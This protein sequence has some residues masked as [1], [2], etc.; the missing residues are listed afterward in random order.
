MRI[1]GA[2]AGF[3]LLLTILW[4]AFETIIL[5]RRVVRYYFRLTRAFYRYT[6]TP[7]AAIA[8][9]LK[10]GRWRESFLSYF[11]PLSLLFLF[12][13][14]A[15]G[16]IFS[17]ALLQWSAGS[18]VRLKGVHPSFWTDLYL[19]GSSFFT[20][21]LGDVVPLSTV[22]RV[23][24][25]IE[26]GT[27]FGMLAVVVTYLPVLYGAFSKREVNISLMDARS[28][29]P[30]TAAELLRRH[31]RPEQ[32]QTLVEYLHDWESWSAELMEI[33]LSYPVLCFFRSQHSNQSWLAALATV[34][35]TSAFLI[36]Q[37]R[38]RL[39][40]QAQLTFAIARHAVVD[41]S[42]VIFSPPEPLRE[43]RFRKEDLERLWALL[44]AEGME[45]E[46]EVDYERLWEL[47]QMYEPYL[48][49]MARRLMLPLPPWRVPQQSLDNWQRTAWKSGLPSKFV[50]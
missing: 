32:V 29:S 8:R 49:G 5:P 19:S 43:D 40:W 15:C 22:A 25:V 11:G 9:R 42:Q 39:Q 3:A 16:L 20:L 2:L 41:L 38:N 46:R 18:V 31:A 36:T 27:G 44:I 21:G 30:P 14:W 4:D 47:R 24:T 35:D 10:P 13:L 23:I 7:W 48:N 33:H 26:S 28:G 45:L 34:L 1:L 37:A 50:I 12:A 6:W 17:F